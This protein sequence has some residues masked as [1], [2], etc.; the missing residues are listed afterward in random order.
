MV[1]FNSYNGL[2][3]MYISMADSDALGQNADEK[4]AVVRRSQRD[5]LFV[6]REQYHIRT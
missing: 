1:E 3:L 5:R 6:S 2:A 4:P